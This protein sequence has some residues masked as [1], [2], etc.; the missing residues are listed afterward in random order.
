M[1][2]QSVVAEQLDAGVIGVGSMGQHHARVYSEL[3]STSLV[4]VT[5][6][7]AEQA[8]TTASA[9]PAPA[10][11]SSAESFPLRPGEPGYGLGLMGDPASPWGLLVGHS[12]GGP[13]YSASAFHAFDLGGLS[14][15]VMGAI[16]ENFS[17]EEIVAGILDYFMS[18]GDGR[19]AQ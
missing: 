7:D 16:E 18:G 15:C 14:V 11:S 1:S 12:G 19:A 9:V 8:A 3:P 17:A 4:G 2:E 10:P 6:V 13:C 5:D